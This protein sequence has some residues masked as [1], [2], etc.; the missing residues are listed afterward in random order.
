MLSAW[1][2]TTSKAP[3]IISWEQDNLH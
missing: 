1:Q 2:T 3:T